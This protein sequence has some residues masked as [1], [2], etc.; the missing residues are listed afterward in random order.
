MRPILNYITAVNVSCKYVY[1][2]AI[3]DEINT[4]CNTHCNNCKNSVYID[5]TNV[6]INMMSTIISVSKS[7]LTGK[8]K[9]I[10]KVLRNL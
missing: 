4:F 8:F 3:S 1:M 6:C 9:N 2:K 5:K 7:Y 10:K